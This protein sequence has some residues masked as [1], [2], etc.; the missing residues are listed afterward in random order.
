[1]LMRVAGYARTSGNYELLISRVMSDAL[2]SPLQ[3]FPADLAEGI[4]TTTELRWDGSAPDLAVEPAYSVMD[5]AVVTA[6]S[7]IKVSTI[8]DQD[9]REDEYE[10]EDACDYCAGREYLCHGSRAGL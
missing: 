1:L 10:V 4:R 9:D 7:V 8:Y 3:A 6:T 5:R 2:T